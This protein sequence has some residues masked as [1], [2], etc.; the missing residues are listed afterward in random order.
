MAVKISHLQNRRSTNGHTRAKAPLVSLD[1][2]GRLRV[3]AMLYFYGVA[4]STFYAGLKKGRYPAPDGYDGTIPYW[5][6]HT[7]RED[8]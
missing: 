4:H 1:E 7:V 5:H 2:P 6:T 8:L 3:S